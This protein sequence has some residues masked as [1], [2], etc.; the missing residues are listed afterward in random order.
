MTSSANRASQAASPA[1]QKQVKFVEA[2]QTLLIVAEQLR[3]QA[4]GRSGGQKE[5]PFDT[6]DCSD[7][8]EG[9]NLAT[10]D[11]ATVVPLYEEL[12]EPELTDGEMDFP[13]GQ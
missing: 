6:P 5:T 9:V 11:E 8:L 1:H 7:L 3:A 4:C 12:Q 13:D 10:L 2:Q